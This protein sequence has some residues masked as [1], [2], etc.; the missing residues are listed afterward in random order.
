MADH[1]THRAA[2]LRPDGTVAADCGLEFRPI[3]LAR[4]RSAL[5]GHP[6]DP[7][8][9]CPTCDPPP[10]PVSELVGLWSGADEIENSDTVRPTNRD[11][12][13]GPL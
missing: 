12:R 5:P 2:T 8:Q 4:G 7:D 3:P 1:D 6:Y 11:A 9:I 13:P 10:A